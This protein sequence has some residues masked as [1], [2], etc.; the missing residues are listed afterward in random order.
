M[1]ELS[2]AQ[3]M[4]QI[5]EETL[6]GRVKLASATVTIGA[7]AG[8][9][10][11]SLRFCFAE[12]AKAEGFGSPELVVNQPPLK[13]RCEDCGAEVTLKDVFEP[14][15]ECGSMNRHVDGG[16]EFTLDS[17]EVLEENGDEVVKKD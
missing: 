9:E 16:F 12:V 7:F 13:A 2:V 15:P 5:V 4:L 6:G 10:V 14:C 11:E 17:I 3:S 8:I 1:H